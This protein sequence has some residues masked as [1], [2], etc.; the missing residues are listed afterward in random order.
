MVENMLKINISYDFLCHLLIIKDNRP[1]V[2]VFV[3]VNVLKNVQ[4]MPG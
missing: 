1:S 4:G 2:C 3:P